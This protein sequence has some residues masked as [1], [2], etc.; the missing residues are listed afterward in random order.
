MAK[1]QG[2]VEC[3]TSG[4]A[5]C[6][7]CGKK[8]CAWLLRPLSGDTGFITD[9]PAVRCMR[10]LGTL[11]DVIN[12]WKCVAPAEG[13]RQ[14]SVWRH[15][16][17]RFWEVTNPDRPQRERTPDQI[18][19]D[20]R[21]ADAAIA[22][23]ERQ[24]DLIHRI[25][26]VKTALIERWE[27][28][29][30]SVGSKT[31]GLAY[32]NARLG[33]PREEDWV[34][35]SLP[36]DVFFHPGLPAFSVKGQEDITT[37]QAA[38]AYSVSKIIGQA[39]SGCSLD[40]LVVVPFPSFER[41][42]ALMCRLTDPDLARLGM[43]FTFL[44]PDGAPR[45][46]P[47][48]D[49]VKFG[50]G[51]LAGG[52]V[53]LGTLEGAAKATFRGVAAGEGLETM[54]AVG[55]ATGLEV[56]VAVGTSLLRSLVPPSLH[57]DGLAQERPQ[58]VV[59]CGDGDRDKGRHDSN[60][61]ERT[62][63]ERSP[64]PSAV[65]AGA[66]SYARLA[67][68][69]TDV[70]VALPDGRSTRQMGPT[71]KDPAAAI[72]AGGVPFAQPLGDVPNVDWLD[73]YIKDGPDAVRRGVLDL[74]I[75]VAKGAD[76]GLE[77]ADRSLTLPTA[78]T[79]FDDEATDEVDPALKDRQL[80]P[81]LSNAKAVR[82]LEWTT[83]AL[84]V[85]LG[86]QQSANRSI[87]IRYWA[88]SWWMYDPTVQRWEQT[89][90]YELRGILAQGIIGQCYETRFKDGQWVRRPYDPGMTKITDLLNRA[91]ALVGEKRSEMPMWL[92]PDTDDHGVLDADA[93]PLRRAK[94]H[95]SILV[96][97]K[98]APDPRRVASFN[99]VLMDLDRLIDP[100]CP[101]SDAAME[102]TEQWFSRTIVPWNP[103]LDRLDRDH[104]SGELY[105]HGYA[106]AD[107][108][109]FMKLLSGLFEMDVGD[110]PAAVNARWSIEALQRWFGYLFI[111][112]ASIQRSLW[113]EGD[114]GTG[115]GT[116]DRV[117]AEA[118]GHDNR[119]GM[120]F[121]ELS[122]RASV[123]GA[124]GRLLL[125]ISEMR[126]GYQDRDAMTALD[127]MLQLAGGDRIGVR[128][129]YER[130][131]P[132]VRPNLRLWVTPNST[133]VIKD[134]KNAMERRWLFLKVAPIDKTRV[135]DTLLER[136][137][138]DELDTI[139]RWMLAGL[140]KVVRAVSLE[141]GAE[142]LQPVRYLQD[143]PAA[144]RPKQPFIDPPSG[145]EIRH[146]LRRNA[147]PLIKFVEDLCVVGPGN[148]CPK[149]ELL[150]WALANA[151]D[152]DLG[153][154]LEMPSFTRRLQ[155]V[156]G[157]AVKPDN[158]QRRG[159]RNPVYVGIRPATPSERDAKK[160]GEQVEPRDWI[161]RSEVEG[162]GID[163]TRSSAVGAGSG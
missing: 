26:M 73:I 20:K 12:G 131:R 132:N 4:Q 1:T 36:R 136:K 6:P 151:D 60:G 146:R 79:P 58:L 10:T 103:D 30:E 122:D 124:I 59:F 96:R 98:P 24:I 84:G 159:V 2:E 162:A 80:M 126:I 77:R 49:N 157:D 66:E 28:E 148:M 41:A 17:D 85:K 13:G 140:I 121:K 57:T 15:E 139:R 64:G 123:A 19:E 116:L 27:G 46:Y 44:D 39:E 16:R 71:P 43:H 145:K 86:T 153:E 87:P 92:P 110:I 152:L 144:I 105:Q 81:S 109:N 95:R 82:M 107:M 106:E 48:Q 91:V 8:W 143:D 75:P 9:E 135:E 119:A 65:L 23:R 31:Q 5:L 50:F 154:R 147:E 100:A 115:K 76:P 52:A 127:T 32:L 133:P 117:I 111:Q 67:H 69:T 158:L 42:P 34:L 7:L 99:S 114:S 112:D 55:L 89:P 88:G 128:D 53:R 125:V 104:R 108:P 74:R 150:E 155:D 51:D 160:R 130:S 22:A 163:L 21:R 62:Q 45:K 102:P 72:A 149:R 113:L 37:G 142:P 120:K 156:A 118:I 40:G 78:E 94:Q 47:G 3:G 35:R 33:H 61:R 56:W 63:L 129:L 141:P 38:R 138:I 90:E 11:G 68:R 93:S 18:A 25:G 137:C 14:G 134:P 101:P 83:E 70:A 54:L 29:A 97:G 161:D